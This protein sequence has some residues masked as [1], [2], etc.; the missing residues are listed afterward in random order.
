[1][2]GP[3]EPTLTVNSYLAP[4]VSDLLD[5]WSGVLLKIPDSDSKAVFRCALLG[6][7]CDLLASRKTCGLTSYSANLGCSRC[8]HHFFPGGGKADYGG[9]FDRSLW[10]SRSNEQHRSD[11]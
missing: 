8:Y 2:P 6:V 7:A 10:R 5:L 9:N 4:L 3:S 1:M 11:V